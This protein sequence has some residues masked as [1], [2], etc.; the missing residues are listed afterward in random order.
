MIDKIQ[1]M[2]KGKMSKGDSSL[3]YLP[4]ICTTMVLLT[5][6]GHNR[7]KPNRSDCELGFE[8]A[9]FENI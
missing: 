1:A 7:G 9:A 5:E 2:Q 3:C 8:V 6:I 4:A